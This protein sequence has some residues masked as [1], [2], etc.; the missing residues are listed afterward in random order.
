MNTLVSMY[1][2]LTEDIIVVDFLTIK[3][4]GD[5]SKIIDCRSL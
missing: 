1:L 3:S 2:F 4:R 5:A